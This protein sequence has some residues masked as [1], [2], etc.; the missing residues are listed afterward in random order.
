M[1]GT[2]SPSEPENGSPSAAGWVLTR[3]QTYGVLIAL[4]AFGFFLRA[5]DISLTPYNIDEGILSILATQ[6]AFL[7]AEEGPALLGLPLVGVRTSFGFHNPPLLV[8]LCAIP[9]RISGDPRFAMVLFA[10]AG[11]GAIGLAGGAARRLWGN[12]AGVAAGALLAFCP[13]AIEHSRR[14][15]GH[16]TILFWSALSLYTAVRSIQTGRKRWMWTSLGCAACA[17]ACHLSGV[18]LWI[19]PL[20]A[21]WLFRVPHWRKTLAV[22]AAVLLAIYLPWLAHQATPGAGSGRAPFDEVALIAKVAL[23]QTAIESRP[24]QIPP[25]LTLA[26]ILVDGFH[27]DLFGREYGAFLF[28]KGWF[29]LLYAAAQGVLAALLAAGLASLLFLARRGW[30]SPGEAQWRASRWSVLLLAAVL[31]PVAAFTILPVESVPPYQLPALVPAALAVARV[32]ARGRRDAPVPYSLPRLA[33]LLTALTCFAMFGTLYTKRSLAYIEDARFQ[34]EVSSVLHFKMD[35]LVYIVG[36]AAN[37]PYSIAQ[38]GRTEAV[39]VDYWVVY[40]H[41]YISGDRR[42]PV[43]RNAPVLYVLLDSKSTLRPEVSEFL[44]HKEQVNF[45]TIGVFRFEGLEAQAWRALVNQFPS[46]RPGP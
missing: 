39:G 9:F 41:Y 33:V 4:M 34:S 46:A 44:R 14:L 5:W 13:N 10:M 16:D 35:A 36:E 32:M 42:L 29:A 1:D 2:T 40:L 23:G 6:A 43:D 17:Q 30:K 3:R 25:A 45:G 22:A 11:A 27:S 19:V 8:W 26:T 38:D 24:T 21:M 18:F 7:R 28:N 15:W 37:R 20:G 31:T 12:W